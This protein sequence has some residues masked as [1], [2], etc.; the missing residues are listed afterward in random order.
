MDTTLTRSFMD[1]C[2]SAKQ[3]VNHLPPLPDWMTPRQVKVIDALHQLQQTHDSIRISDVANYLQGTMPSITRMVTDLEA[4][5]ALNKIPCH[6]DK[7]AHALT[8]TAY[9]EELYSKYVEGFHSHVASL[10]DEIT[11]EDMSTTISVIERA[12]ELLQDDDFGKND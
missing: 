7:R 10:L 6:S 5:A 4:H 8:L 9:G 1:A 2:T 3:I 12:W 11:D